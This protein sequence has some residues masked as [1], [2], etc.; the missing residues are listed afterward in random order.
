VDIIIS[1][2]GLY[3]LDEL[4]ILDD[5]IKKLLSNLNKEE[6]ETANELLDKMRG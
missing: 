1:A 2:K 4:G 5:Y 6:A 3:L